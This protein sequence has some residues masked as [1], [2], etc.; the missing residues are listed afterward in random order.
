MLSLS[1]NRTALVN[2]KHTL[3]A[4]DEI[5][6]LI[7]Y[8]SEEKLGPAYVKFVLGAGPMAEINVQIDR[9]IMVA[10]LTAQEQKLVNYLKTLGID[11]TE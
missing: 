7:G 8:Y 3:M 1:E 4:L 10:A 11:A 2:L 5:R 6:N 9:P